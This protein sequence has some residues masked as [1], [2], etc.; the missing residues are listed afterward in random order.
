MQRRIVFR[1]LRPSSL[2]G[3]LIAWRLGEPWSHV[4]VLFDDCAYSAQLPLVAMLPLISP[5]VSVPPR[6]GTDIHIDVDDADYQKMQLWC[7]QEV[8]M[9]YDIL[10][11]FGWI[12]GW[13]VLQSKTNSYCF[14][15]CRRLLVHM[16]WL[17][18]SDD[19]IKGNR[20]IE[21][22]DSMMAQHI[23]QNSETATLV[24]IDYHTPA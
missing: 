18:D 11:I 14:E 19:L 9:T 15:F 3:R 6:T 12:L 1:F 16:N 23:I 8:G 13:K 22:I 24:K 21:D 7:Q 2:V 4:C 10:S 17:K 20:L 5:D